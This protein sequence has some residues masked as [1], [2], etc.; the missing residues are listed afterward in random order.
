MNR[1]RKFLPYWQAIPE[2]LRYQA[3]SKFFLGILL[4]GLNTVTVLLLLS[5]G[6]LSVSTGDFAFLFTTWQGPLLITA[7]VFSLFLFVAFDL[8]T[9]IVYA[10]KLMQKQPVSVMAGVR[11][12]VLAVRRLFTP[13]GIGVVIY[14][15]LIAPIIG[16]GISISLT[17]SLAIPN[18]ISSVIVSTPLYSLLYTAVIIVF[19]SV[20]V[21]HLFCLHAMVIDHLSVKDA[22]QRSRSLMK[23][24]WKD[25]LRKSLVYALVFIFLDILIVLVL[26]I[27]PY[28]LAVNLSLSK[29]VTRGLLVFQCLTASGIF[30]ALQLLATPFY[31]MRITELYHSYRDGAPA[32][33]PVRQRKMHPF[34]TAAVILLVSAIAG[35]AWLVNLYFDRFF[36][37]S[38][39]V[40]VIAHRAGGSEAPENTIAG[41][42]KA[43]E[44]G[45]YGAEIDIQRTK[46]GYYIVNHDN[47]FKRTCGVSRTPEEMTL[48]EIQQLTVRYDKDPDIHAR[49]ASLEEMLEKARGNLVLFVELKGRSADEQMVDDAVRLIRSCGMEQETVLIS[50]KYSLINYAETNYPDIATGYLTFASY[51]DISALNC[52]YLGIEEEAATMTVIDTIHNAGKKVMVW[53]PNLEDSQYHFLLTEADAIITDEISQ[54][55]HLIENME[56]R[57]DLTRIIDGIFR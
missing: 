50:L 56:K 26:M 11:E 44:T 23:A 13:A 16:L 20:G 24:H 27:L 43:M 15:A 42:E 54:A 5:T 35:A 48:A 39:T 4:T 9:K 45:A 17:E 30:G 36:P 18:F 32:F 19:A 55:H 22:L 33:L 57:D 51:G 53:T 12:G 2:I 8:N 25:F 3:V 46:D 21:A 10:E 40:Q 34:R 14:I 52:D 38:S 31:L 37:L 29:S 28:L 41:L 7:A 49:P 6:R 47:D 1:L